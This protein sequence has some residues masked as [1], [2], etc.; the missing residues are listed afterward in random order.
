MASDTS[1]K[2]KIVNKIRFRLARWFVSIVMVLYAAG[3]AASLFVFES[4]LARSIDLGLTDLVAE[5]RPS[6]SFID[7][8]P[9]LSSWSEHARAEGTH[10]LA[11]VQLYDRHGKMI[12]TYGP[13]G[14][15]RLSNGPTEFTHESDK[16]SLRS[17]NMPLERDGATIGY[18]QVQVATNSQE[19]AAKQ[20]Q[21]AILAIAPLLA[22]GVGI[23]A[24]L[25]SG[26]A[27]E[28]IER[29]NKLLRRFVADAGHELNTPVATIEACLQTLEDPSKLGDMSEEVFDM[30]NRSS[31]R[32]R[33]LAKDL[34]VLARV[35]DPEADLRRTRVNLR[36][37]AE[38]VVGEFSSTA[39]RR[40]ISLEVGVFPDVL[41]LAHEESIHEIF[42]NLIDNA[43][44]YSED[45]GTVKI[46]AIATDQTISIT[47]KDAGVG[48]A[49]ENIDLIFDR[50]FRVDP[51]R[52]RTIGGSGLGL[53][54]V[55]A[56]VDR[57]NGQIKVESEPGV[58]TRFTVE[59]PL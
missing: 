24:Y 51:S 8:H 56:A 18:L 44:K 41:L 57:H 35:E 36:D 33:H 55:K 53:S 50:F 4:G 30:L 19:E 46:S 22:A 39:S 11:T 45:G 28:P 26:K 49:R 59:L 25:F 38:S 7:G 31:D 23:G 5:I 27:V 12:E 34:I 42:N 17:M 47:V 2:V 32:L 3:A 10:I 13:D 15:S 37:M 1:C 16:V 43:I 6:V 54:I 29:T 48:I 9:T 21:I 58:G 14:D 20:F 52:S 40:N